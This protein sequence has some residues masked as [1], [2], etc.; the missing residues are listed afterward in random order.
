VF[1]DIHINDAYKN[2]FRVI[3]TM[4]H[5]D[6]PMTYGSITKLI[7]LKNAL[8]VVFEHGIGLINIDNNAAHSS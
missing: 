4:N 5:K 2:G 7:E 8:L 6:Y 1:S 3:R